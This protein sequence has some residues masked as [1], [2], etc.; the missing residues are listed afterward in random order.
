MSRCYRHASKEAVGACVNC[1]ELVCSACHKEIEGKTYCQACVDKLSATAVITPAADTATSIKVAAQTSSPEKKEKIETAP[2][3]QSNKSVESKAP[4]ENPAAAGAKTADTGIN[5]AWW[6]P[7]VVLG[8]IG[9]L[10]SWL[11][12]K[13]SSPKTALHMLFTGIGMTLVQIF[14]VF[15]I[16]FAA[17]VPTAQIPVVKLTSAGPAEINVPADN[18]WTA[19][20]TKEKGATIQAEGMSV[21]VPSGAAKSDTEIVVKEYIHL[22]PEYYVAKTSEPPPMA[23]AVGKVYDVGPAGIQFD[24]PVQITI[25]YDKTLVPNDVEAKDITM[26]YWDGKNWIVAG[27]V[28]DAQKGT[29]SISATD[30][31]GSPVGAALIF[32]ATALLTAYVAYHQNFSPDPR[33]RGATGELVTPDNDTV[34]ANAAK[35]GIPKGAE[36]PVCSNCGFKLTSRNKQ[37]TWER[38]QSETKYTCPKCGSVTYHIPPKE[39][40][41]LEDPQH[42]GQLNPEIINDTGYK[43][44]GFKEKEDQPSQAKYPNY[45]ELVAGSDTNWDKPDAFVNKGMRGDCTGVANAVLSMLRGMGVEAYGVDGEINGEKGWAEHAWVEF[46]YQGKPYYYDNN[47]GIK[48]L[49]DVSPRLYHPTF[50]RKNPFASLNRGYMWN[51]KGQ[52]AYEEGWWKITADK[53]S[54]TIRPPGSTG[55]VEQ[56]YTFIAR[57]EKIPPG[58]KMEWTFSGGTDEAVATYKDQETVTHEFK[59]KGQKTVAVQYTQGG[60]IVASDKVLFEIQDEPTLDVILP[61]P[62]STAGLPLDPF[63][64]N[65]FTAVPNNIPSAAVYA[66]YIGGQKMDEGI[67]KTSFTVREKT[68][69][70]GKEYEVTVTADWKGGDLQS[71]RLQATK[72]FSVEG[73]SLY[74]ESSLPKDGT[75]KVCTEY[76]FSAKFRDTQSLQPGTTFEWTI[77]GTQAGGNSDSIAYIFKNYGSIPVTVKATWQTGGTTQSKDASY[78]VQIG[79]PKIVLKG[80]KELKEGEKGTLYEYYTF[81]FEPQNIPDSAIYQIDGRP[82]DLGKDVTYKMLDTG[83]QSVTVAAHW[84][85]NDCK[86]NVSDTREF[87]VGE[88]TIDQITATPTPG[89]QNQQTTFKAS[90]KYIPKENCEFTWELGK[91]QGSQKTPSTE[92]SISYTY[93]DAGDYDIIVSL[94][95]GQT[96]LGLKLLTYHVNAGPTLTLDMPPDGPADKDYVFKANPTNIPPGALYT[97]SINGTQVIQGNDKKTVTTK[98]NY[99]KAGHTYKFYVVATWVEKTAAGG[100]ATQK[101]EARDTFNPLDAAPVLSIKLP[102]PAPG[103]PLDPTKPNSFYAES[104]GI[105]VDTTTYEWYL[106]EKLIMTG[107]GKD[108]SE[109]VANVGFFKDGDYEIMVIAKWLGTDKK[110][111]WTQASAS[112]KVANTAITLAIIPPPDIEAGKGQPKTSYRFVAAGE[113]IPANAIY[114]WSM[115]D[116]VLGQGESI[117]LN[118]SVAGQYKLKLVARWTGAGG[119]PQQAEAGLDLRIS[120]PAASSTGRGWYLVNT[121]GFGTRGV[122]HGGTITNANGSSAYIYT[123]G[124]YQEDCT[125]SWTSFPDFLPPGRYAL[126]K[127]TKGSCLADTGESYITLY[128]YKVKDID[129]EP[130]RAKPIADNVRDKDFSYTV[131]D[132]S[133]G[134]KLLVD[135]RC[136]GEVKYLYE[137][138]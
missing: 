63:K 56:P 82:A 80:P 32:G 133:P 128:I 47:E 121:V 69:Q 120:E 93:S 127:S 17:V 94:R 62:A 75:G 30:F 135:L 33:V 4:A 91:G 103:Q 81:S 112:F 42:P 37:Q 111:Q 104:T 25:P 90:G 12:N 126:T 41:P 1:G 92:T 36:Q 66:W 22:P 49:Q 84:E 118:F 122:V 99:F 113:N 68:F 31:P 123:N 137:Y 86:G 77:D 73:E 55:Y 95:E 26:I 60:K 38:G 50:L 110:E 24:K 3:L 87:E 78:K 109:A 5:W 27:G 59:S 7:P 131:P 117:P 57:P 2:A 35:A 58:S 129:E 71:R 65:I 132:G 83:S 79:E 88:P 39:W 72:A 28:V 29:V 53:P 11:P 85:K 98:A 102:P 48:P 115:G 100:T 15:I 9:G 74:I 124:D 45:Q 76:T 46:V 61:A 16:I 125:C 70:P 40:V 21:K 52:K 108:G 101:A 23:L 43:Q 119:Q 96:L 13:D 138:R 34:K 64:P 54:V 51:E 67:K 10:I 18:T 6:I 44:I 14:M 89:I 114:T 130:F 19:K 97:W 106:N 134:E 116:R 8:W 105:P 136:V 20:A 107:Q